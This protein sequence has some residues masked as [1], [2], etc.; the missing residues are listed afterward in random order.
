VT[1]KRSDERG[2]VMVELAII[3]PVLLMLLVGIMEFGKYYSTK[4]SLQ[5]AAR[6]GARELA[7]GHDLTAI[8]NAVHANAPSALLS[9]PPT[10][11][12]SGQP[13]TVTVTQDHTFRIPFI[14]I[15]TETLT[16]KG[17]MRCGL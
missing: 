8:N 3:L 16:A 10:A 11:C 17:V 6:E 7:L 5:A 1:K 9:P 15:R 14:P 12:T 2:A 13:A 4:V